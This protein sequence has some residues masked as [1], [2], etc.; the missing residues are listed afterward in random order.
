MSVELS[1]TGA[2]PSTKLDEL[3][4]GFSL[5]LGASDAEHALKWLASNLTDSDEDAWLALA[6]KL[7][8]LRSD[9]AATLQLDWL[10]L[11]CIR[12][13]S[14]ARARIFSGAVRAKR[15]DWVHA[16]G[17]FREAIHLDPA[18]SDAGFGLA[19]V[20]GGL[21]RIAE[22]SQAISRLAAA[23]DSG[24]VDLQFRCAD[25]LYKSRYFYDALNICEKLSQ[26]SIPRAD[27]SLLKAELLLAVGELDAAQASLSHLHSV[28]SVSQ[29]ISAAG[30]L[31]VLSDEPADLSAVAAKLRT[32]LSAPALSDDL[33]ARAFSALAVIHSRFGERGL[34]VKLWREANHITAVRSQWRRDVWIQEVKRKL[35][36]QRPRMALEPSQM[37]KPL[38]IVGLPLSGVEWLEWLLSR[39]S[40]ICVRG[41]LQALEL[42]AGQMNGIEDSVDE[43]SLFEAS[44]FYCTQSIQDNINEN[45]WIVDSAPYNFKFLDIFARMFPDAKVVWCRRRPRDLALHLWT[46]N[47]NQAGGFA[48]SYENIDAMIK[49][50]ERLMRHWQ[51]TLPI[52]VHSVAYE[53]LLTHP[54]SILRGI[55]QFLGLDED[56]ATQRFTSSSSLLNDSVWKRIHSWAPIGWHPGA[57][58]DYLAYI[59]EL[60]QFHS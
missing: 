5:I 36:L 38:L 32:A 3:L 13:P 14:S 34:A 27:V 54:A 20:L 18:N 48:W 60:R 12:W 39:Q 2:L 9:D 7:A 19:T 16:E 51:D 47:S 21:G 35:A 29:Q 44:R 4:G 1:I 6:E 50:S 23:A 17:R 43:Y 10:D 58:L 30:R 26:K 15:G 45:R 11:S 31:A 59:P 40:G 46:S 41:P 24:N 33:R 57:A 42:I 37:F 8:T 53:D 49:G 52:S 55:G 25:F 28:G 56:E 22:A